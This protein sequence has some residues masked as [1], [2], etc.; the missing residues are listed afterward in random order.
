MDA[1]E[2]LYYLL[3]HVKTG[4]Y[5]INTF[6]DLFTTIF[7]IE[8]DKNSLSEQE[9]KTFSILEGFTCRFSPYEEDFK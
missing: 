4:D 5:D 6:S 9:L 2:Q 7:N 3:K 8:C 1:K